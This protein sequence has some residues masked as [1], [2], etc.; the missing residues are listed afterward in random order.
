MIT[1]EHNIFENGLESLQGFFVSVIDKTSN[2]TTIYYD[3]WQMVRR[4]LT[5]VSSSG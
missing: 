3:F 4:Y 5:G 1:K 2:D